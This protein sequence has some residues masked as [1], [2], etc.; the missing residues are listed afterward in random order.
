MACFCIWIQ[1]ASQLASG[2]GSGQMFCKEAAPRTLEQQLQEH[3]SAT[4]AFTVQWRPEA[5]LK[6]FSLSV[7]L[8]R[9]LQQK[10][11]YLQKQSQ[12]QAYFHQMQ[13]AEDAYPPAQDPQLS[14]SPLPSP[15]FTR[16]QTL[17]P[18]LEP[19]TSSLTYGPKSARFPDWPLPPENHSNYTPSL[20]TEPQYAWSPAQPPLPPGKAESLSAQPAPEAPFL[21]CEMM[22]SVEAPQGCVLVN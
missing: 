16:T 13:L 3:R 9:R 22:E 6:S 15:P 20:P 8:F 21:D 4:T 11:L 18:F 5:V 10:R 1:R 12:V 7:I 19:G 2:L 14:S 17:T